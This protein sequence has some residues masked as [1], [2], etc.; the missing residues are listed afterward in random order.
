MPIAFVDLKK[1]PPAAGEL[2][3]FA[4]KFGAR[5]LLDERRWEVLRGL[6]AFEAA[7]L[8]RMRKAVN[9][10]QAL[11]ETLLL[12]ARGE[13]LDAQTEDVAVA[14]VIAEAAKDGRE[15]REAARKEVPAKDAPA[16]DPRAKSA[17]A[18]PEPAPAPL[19]EAV[20]LEEIQAENAVV[21]SVVIEETSDPKET[22]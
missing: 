16:K 14:D 19:V 15:T 17:K 11:L 3:R 10:M 4:Q 1:R 7:A 22:V 12:L 8:A 5:A 6:P 2:K 18:K 21:E 9:E 20:V 13:E